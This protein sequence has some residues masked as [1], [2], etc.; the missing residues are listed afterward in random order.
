[1]ANQVELQ[2]LLEEL[3]ESRNV[4]YMPPENLKMKYDA[5]RYVK[6]D[7][8]VDYASDSA[9]A[10]RDRY[11]LTVISRL[12]FLSRSLSINSFSFDAS[13]RVR[14]YVSLNML[15]MLVVFTI[16][17]WQFLVY[18]AKISSKITV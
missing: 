13:R 2:S 17:S 8:R 3:L 11:E 7:I 1:M 15:P 12:P 5:I 16:T 14:L 4:Y 18:S 10:M 6:T 9:Y